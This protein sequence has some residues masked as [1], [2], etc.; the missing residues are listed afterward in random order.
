MSKII[1]DNRSDLDIIKCL[2]LVA[3]VIHMGRISNKGKQYC[4]LTVFEINGF[5]YQVST[6]LRG[7]SDRFLIIKE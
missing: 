1:I 6:D 3:S 5:N 7:K 2:K 4:Y